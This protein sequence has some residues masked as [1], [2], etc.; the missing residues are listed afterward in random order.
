MIRE[1]YNINPYNEAKDLSDNPQFSFT[2]GGD[3][4]IG[5]DYKIQDNFNKNIILR[6]WEH[7]QEGSSY[8]P[9]V[10]SG[11]VANPSTQSSNTSV[12]I[13]NDEDYYFNIDKINNTSLYNNKG[14]V[15]QL[16]LFEDNSNPTNTIQTGEI[17]R[18]EEIANEQAKV[19]GTI[20]GL[21]E[22]SEEYIFKRNLG[23]SAYES[24]GETFYKPNRWTH[25]V[26]RIG[27][28]I[29]PIV[30]YETH[31]EVYFTTTRPDT[32]YVSDEAIGDGE[33]EDYYQANK[34]ITYPN[35]SYSKDGDSIVCKLTSNQQKT[36]LTR[37]NFSDIPKNVMVKSGGSIFTVDDRI[38][39]KELGTATSNNVS[40]K[41][42]LQ[43]GG[44]VTQKVTNQDTTEYVPVYY[45]VQYP[46]ISE[47][48]SQVLLY[49]FSVEQITTSYTSE[50]EEQDSIANLIGTRSV[51]GLANLLYIDQT[52]GAFKS[53]N[54]YLTEEEIAA[55][56]T[57]IA[58]CSTLTQLDTST[59]M[60]YNTLSD[61]N[62]NFDIEHETT[63]YTIEQED[64]V[65][66]YNG[67]SATQVDLTRN[68]AKELGIL[69]S[70]EDDFLVVKSAS[71]EL[72]EI[73][74]YLFTLTETQNFQDTDYGVYVLSQGL[75][76]D[77]KQLIDVTT[78]VGSTVGDL[79]ENDKISFT[80]LNNYY[81]SNYYYLTNQIQ[82]DLHFQVDG[83]PYYSFE[84]YQEIP[85]DKPT[86]SEEGLDNDFLFQK[87]ERDNLSADDFTVG[88]ESNPLVTL[89]RF[90]PIKS[91]LVGLGYNFKYYTFSIFGGS[92]NSDGSIIYETNPLYTSEKEFSYNIYIDYNNY[93]TDYDRYK[94]ELSLA[95]SENGFYSYFLYL[96]PTIDMFQDDEKDDR[97]AFVSYD[98]D[99]G[100]A[101]L[102]WT[103]DNAY[104]PVSKNVSQVTY[105]TYE[106][107]GKQFPLNG[108]QVGSDG[109]LSYYHKGSQILNISPLHDF[110]ISFTINRVLKGLEK[111]DIKPL[112]AFYGSTGSLAI[113]LQIEDNNFRLLENNLAQPFT[114][115]PSPIIEQKGSITNVDNLDSDKNKIYQYALP[116]SGM[117]DEDGV[118]APIEQD[119]KKYCFHFYLFPWVPTGSTQ[120]YISYRLTRFYNAN[121]EATNELILSSDDDWRLGYYGENAGN[122]AE[123]TSDGNNHL[124]G[125]PKDANFDT[126][127]FI[128]V[129]Y[130]AGARPQSTWF[131]GLTKINLYG[132]AIYYG[133]FDVN[134]RGQVSSEDNFIL[135]FNDSLVGFSALD[136]AVYGYRI[137][138][139]SYLND[140]INYRDAA[141][142]F[143]NELDQI[144]DS[145]CGSITLN[146]SQ[147]TP[148]GTYDDI[149]NGTL[150][151]TEWGEDEGSTV[152]LNYI[153]GT[154][155]KDQINKSF[156]VLRQTMNDYF[157]DR[158]TSI[159]FLAE[160]F[161]SIYSFLD[162]VQ[163][164]DMIENELIAEVSL[165]E[166][167]SISEED[168]FYILYDYTVPNKGYYRYQIV[169]LLRN[170]TY[171]VL[172]AKLNDLGESVIQIDD[173][174]WHMTNIAKRTDGSYS[175]DYTWNFILGI[176]S[177]P[178]IQ[179]FTKTI[180]S[181]F[182]PYPKI[183]T[184]LTNYKTVQFTGYLGEFAFGQNGMKNTYED[185]ITI[186]EKWNE[187]AYENNQILVKDPKGHVFIAAITATQDTS[188]ITIEEM[189]TQ[190][191]CS[192]VQVGDVQSTK[193]YAL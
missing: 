153:S 107:E 71:S 33:A 32:Y 39:K 65:T 86:T 2:F 11:T 136:Q 138:R 101:K 110:Q 189:P 45:T 108:Y 143:L 130:L 26:M 162:E 89:Q 106:V 150:Y 129:S 36:S 50:G 121:S 151:V 43:V 48:Q 13:Y 161:G 156:D 18:I 25:N 10:E 77:Y 49:N 68:Q 19:R 105:G 102:S 175:P 79:A 29:F 154:D 115:N 124:V 6:D 128:S 187:F 181:G 74:P 169:P 94:I 69:D 93:V 90:F 42:Y 37:A 185:N 61:E 152:P 170:K 95:T 176:Q 91:S 113:Q 167:Y 190:V 82:P 38:T 160:D 116:T 146:N 15:W 44:P 72:I 54:N 62:L 149:I 24:N 8:I 23:Y 180:Q 84:S 184:S 12:T 27:Q 55:I 57:S 118:I 97:F 142:E 78:G 131:Q 155:L 109:Y 163:T 103:K 70:D 53:T 171:N 159:N 134:R 92:I 127:E 75:S 21:L 120:A 125:D 31:S 66:K 166:D 114:P 158:S 1:P 145:I 9:T 14:L 99:K 40:T 60:S 157:E 100:A 177:A 137:F 182:A 56:G 51:L 34:I 112:I 85:G 148:I 179:N 135:N 3:A 144:Y 20:T 4:L 41:L 98:T 126:S 81:D 133:I 183:M 28:N 119:L 87:K 122:Q 16:R 73:S 30:D 58:V 132:D 80:V 191:S 111:I 76:P 46:G 63:I 168:G 165:I 140:D 188:D 59:V 164:P 52:T 186:I 67:T 96:Y 117:L 174:F 22:E 83:V 104:P 5:Y 123:V 35:Y 178:Y 64:T 88:S 193:V 192:M 173:E 47:S 17:S 141:L 147:H 172:I 7:I 139:N